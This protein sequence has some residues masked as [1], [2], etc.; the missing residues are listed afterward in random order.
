MKSVTVFRL[1]LAACLFFS[2]SAFG[3]GSYKVEAIGAPA[4]SDVPKTLLDALEAQGARVA[5]DQGA[6]CEVWLRKAMPLKAATGGSGEVLYGALSN[7]TVLGVLRFPSAA[8]D[9]RGQTI[10]PG[11]YVM[12]YAL[13]PQD[14]SHMG[15]YATRDAVVL[16]PVAA[17]TEVTKDLAF[18]DLV[19]LSRLASGTPHPAFLVM[20]PVSEGQSFPSVVKDDQEHWNLQLKV[21]GQ[22][23]ELPIA[24][25]LVGKWEGA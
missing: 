21:K 17:D 1:T 4:S 25:T 9:F 5:G 8:A 20:S 3:Q 23:G 18:D 11:Y 16:S 10:K 7:G 19:K 2:L 13:I 15:V 22:S 14:G 24:I 12:R 6:V